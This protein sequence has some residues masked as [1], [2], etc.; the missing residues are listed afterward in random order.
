VTDVGKVPP[1]LLVA[2]RNAGKLFE[3]VP[4]IEAA[5]LRP[6]SLSESGIAPSPDEDALERFETFEENALAKARYFFA[7]G[8][9]VAVLAD[10]SGLVVEALDGAPGVRSK[11]WSSTAPGDAHTHAQ[12]RPLSIDAANNRALLDALARAPD[13]R[14]KFVCV[15][16]IVWKGGTVRARGE[17]SGRIVARERG[18][19]GFGYDPLFF[20]DEL[21]KTFGEATREEKAHVSHR[22]RAVRAV[23]DEFAESARRVRNAGVD[24]T[25][26]GR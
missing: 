20:S 2:T 9:G 5:G 22:A 16:A 26:D 13:R 4:M 10:D 15:A 12:E 19:H 21:S 1:A 23:L 24:R 11:R 17:I 14:A 3:V 25:R 8:D 7:R 6:L 18:S